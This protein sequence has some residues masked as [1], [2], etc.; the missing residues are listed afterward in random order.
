M[1]KRVWIF[2]GALAV[3]LILFALIAFLTPGG[4]Q[5]ADWYAEYVNRNEAALISIARGELDPNQ[6]FRAKRLLARGGIEH[7]YAEGNQMRFFIKNNMM[8]GHVLLVYDPEGN[9]P[10]CL[11][12]YDNWVFEETENGVCKWTGGMAGKAYILL[13]D[14]GNDFYLEEAYLPT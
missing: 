14:L 10:T 9:V 7:I 11:D 3:I 8:E 6:S 2:C 13:Y 4:S 1:K 5:D 12:F